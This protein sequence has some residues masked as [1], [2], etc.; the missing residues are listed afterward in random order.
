MEID[1]VHG[2]CM[3]TQIGKKCRERRRARVGKESVVRDWGSP[4]VC[5]ALGG[6]ALA[7]RALR[8][9]LGAWA[10]TR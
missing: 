8:R 10:E 4:S 5:P 3:G 2:M 7:C 9:S 1:P 6:M